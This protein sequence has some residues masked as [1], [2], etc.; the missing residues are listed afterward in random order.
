MKIYL[1]T[2]CINRVFDDQSQPRIFLESSAMITILA[3]I[4]S[5]ALSLV[6]S[7]VLLFEN[8]RNPFEERR[9][10]VSLVL[11]K[12]KVIQ[13]V[14]PTLLNR[15]QQIETSDAISGLDA[16]HL[17]CAEKLKCSYFITCDDRIVRRYT[18]LV[19]AI[20]PV[21]FTVDQL[22]EKDHA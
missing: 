13:T 3:M 12:A 15:A 16:L 10:F 17:A 11:A 8:A 1:D 14:S 4:E 22:K 2:S 21:Q 6:S 19:K 18:G 9:V 5:T 20:N 7:E